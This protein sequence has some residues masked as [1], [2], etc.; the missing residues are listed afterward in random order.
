MWR[1][2]KNTNGGVLLLVKL[3]FS[4]CNLAE[5]NTP[6]R[7]F[8]YF[9]GFL[10]CTNGTNS[11][12]ASKICTK[13]SFHMKKEQNNKPVWLLIST[14]ENITVTNLIIDQNH[15]YQNHAAKSNVK[16]RCVKMCLDSVKTVLRYA[17]FHIP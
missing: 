5:S 8:W 17:K 4:V 16:I 15:R 2:V 11:R 9:S 6:P 13:Y 3:Q 7:V 12:K 14:R 1:N 10:N